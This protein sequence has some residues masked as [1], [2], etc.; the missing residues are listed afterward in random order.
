MTPC[1]ATHSTRGFRNLL[2]RSLWMLNKLKPDPFFGSFRLNKLRLSEFLTCDTSDC[3]ALSTKQANG[4]KVV[5]QRK[6]TKITLRYDDFCSTFVFVFFFT[7]G[8]TWKIWQFERLQTLVKSFSITQGK[9]LKMCSPIQ[10]I[11]TLGV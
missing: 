9:K 4:I 1:L 2:R 3:N 10:T 7:G 6:K 11:F 5:A 8:W